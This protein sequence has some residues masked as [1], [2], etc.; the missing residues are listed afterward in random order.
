MQTL[1]AEKL[2][3]SSPRYI[4]CYM[5]ISVNQ[6][7]YGLQQ[8]SVLFSSRNGKNKFDSHSIIFNAGTLTFFVDD[9]NDSNFCFTERKTFKLLSL[10][11]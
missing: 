4:H 7:V 6:K 8:Q 1:G 10:H 3:F 2:T 9:L 5:F 11:L